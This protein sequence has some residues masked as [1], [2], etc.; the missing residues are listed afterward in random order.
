MSRRKRRL[1]VAILAFIIGFLLGIADVGAQGPGQHSPDFPNPYFPPERADVICNALSA[2]MRVD[3]GYEYML[4]RA[5]EVDSHTGYMNFA[6]AVA[7]AIDG[8]EERMQEDWDILPYEGHFLLPLHV[9]YWRSTIELVYWNVNH[10]DE[11]IP[12]D[13]EFRA[14]YTQKAYIG[15]RGWLVDG[16]SCDVPDWSEV[17]PYPEAVQFADSYIVPDTL[18]LAPAEDAT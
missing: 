5:L 17:E 12:R 9:A 10:G 13:M 1:V 15:A 7:L 6:Y 4:L 2:T 18:P 3:K 11:P 14:T 16:Y 8:T